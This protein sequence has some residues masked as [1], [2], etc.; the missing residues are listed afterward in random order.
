[1]FSPWLFFSLNCVVFKP[2]L[3]VLRVSA[4]IKPR[5]LCSCAFGKCT[6]NLLCS[7]KTAIPSLLCWHTA[8]T[9]YPLDD[10]HTTKHTSFGHCASSEPSCC[11]A[12]SLS[13]R[14]NVKMMSEFPPL[15][16][17]THNFFLG[18]EWPAVCLLE[19]CISMKSQS[20]K[21][22]KIHTLLKEERERV[23]VVKEERKGRGGVY[24]VNE[25]W[26]VTF[27]HRTLIFSCA[28]KTAKIYVVRNM[29]SMSRRTKRFFNTPLLSESN[30]ENV[31]SVSATWLL[32][33]LV[34]YLLCVSNRC[35]ISKDLKVGAGI[36]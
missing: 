15:Q 22:E 4:G 11:L 9:P 36:R 6:L 12:P 13:S 26:R 33:W 19:I 24:R 3:V 34:Q 8:R 17:N 30:H 35:I 21:K 31:R 28:D 20:R 32:P 23:K 16:L 1:M 10:M 2:R 18:L 5:T 25:K 29:C 14:A 7:L 27:F